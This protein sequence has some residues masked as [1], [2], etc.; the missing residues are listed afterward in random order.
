MI[1]GPIR[2]SRPA[3]SICGVVGGLPASGS[4]E[5]YQTSG[6]TPRAVSESPRG[7]TRTRRKFLKG[8]A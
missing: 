6:R 4:P 1:T 7:I 3:E 8:S 5:L 2:L